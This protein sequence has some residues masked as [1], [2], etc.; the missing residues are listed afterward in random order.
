MTTS[1]RDRIAELLDQVARAGWA[2]EYGALIDELR[3][4]IQGLR[5]QFAAERGWLV[6]AG[7]LKLAAECRGD[8]ARHFAMYRNAERFYPYIDHPDYF[9]WAK[10][11]DHPAAIL[12][13]SYAKPAE[14][15]DFAR[16]H[17]LECE[18][19]EWSWYH[20]GRCTAALLMPASNVVPLETM[21]QPTRGN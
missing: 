18:F 4:T 1:P 11:P 10:A 9:T 8:A 5:E 15:A 6:T 21:T 16:Q 17:A 3:E 19:L 14:L 13:H 12:T 20:P 2:R 7:H